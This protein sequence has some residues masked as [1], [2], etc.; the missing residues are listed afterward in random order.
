MRCIGTTTPPPI[1]LGCGT[2]LLIDPVAASFSRRPITAVNVLRSSSVAMPAVSFDMSCAF[3]ARSVS[4]SASRVPVRMN[5]SPRGN[6]SGGG[7]IARWPGC[8]D[9]GIADKGVADA[10]AATRVAPMLKRLLMTPFLAVG[11]AGGEDGGEGGRGEGGR[12]ELGGDGGGEL[13]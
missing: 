10:D 12:G 2:L 13:K 7:S 9:A 1:F 11:C 4:R 6:G 3:M 5:E 8:G